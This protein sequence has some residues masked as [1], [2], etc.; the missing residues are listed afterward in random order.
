MRMKTI[1]LLAAVILLTV[2]AAAFTYAGAET[3]SFRNVSAAQKYV[4]ENQPM[5][6]ILE[7]VKFKPTELLSIKAEL[8][9]GAAFHFTTKWGKIQFSD[10]TTEL[11]LSQRKNVTVSDLDAI[12][13]ICP[14]IK[15]IDSS[16]TYIGNAKMIALIEKYP[17]IQFEWK[18]YLGKSHYITTKATAY[19]TFNE[20]GN[21]KQLTSEDLELLRYCPRLKALDLGHNNIKNLEFLKYVPD[22]ELLIVG[23]NYIT[24]ITPLGQLKHLQYLEI[25][26]NKFTDLTPLSN[27]HE[28]LDVNLTATSIDDLTALDDI[29]TIERLVVN[30]CK[31]LPKESVEHFKEHHPTCEVDY[32]PSHSATNTEKPWRKHPRYKHYIWCL[33]NQTWIPFNEPLPTK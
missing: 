28:L 1:R 26:L 14:N 19:S 6:L 18:I 16:R 22:L 31:Y 24:D 9:E 12:A 3:M 30:M 10:E 29:T 4:R 15:M 23:H 11:D 20:I 17:D 13:Q 21:G 32:K 7:N 33:K 2:C 5:E 8:P 27:C 25:F